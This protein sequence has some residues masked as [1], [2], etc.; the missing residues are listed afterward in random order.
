MT[1]YHISRLQKSSFFFVCDI[2]LYVYI[3]ILCYFSYSLGV[4]PIFF[5]TSMF[6]RR[7][8]QQ[9]SLWLIEIS[10]HTRSTINAMKNIYFR[11]VVTCY[12]VFEGLEIQII[13]NINSSISPKNTIHKIV[14]QLLYKKNSIN[15]YQIAIN[16]L[17][18]YFESNKSFIT[19]I[20]NMC[21]YVWEFFMLWCCVF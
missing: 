9:N 10:S 11:K 21:I 16:R 18:N 6:L 2:Q 4:V 14:K 17:Y 3:F 1:W 12:N 13:S 15:S 19:P 20:Q 8:T 7:I 5:I